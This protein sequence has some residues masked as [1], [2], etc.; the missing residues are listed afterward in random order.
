MGIG[1]RSHRALIALILAL[2]L[3]LGAGVG[4]AEAKKKGGGKSRTLS[5]TGGPG[6]VPNGPTSF[7]CVFI[8][9]QPNTNPV[10]L[11]AVATV[12]KKASGKVITDVDVTLS[13][14]GTPMSNNLGAVTDLIVRITGPDG[15]TSNLVLGARNCFFGCRAGSVSG[16][17]I[18]GLTL[19]DQTA[20]R[21][22]STFQPPPPPP[23]GDPDA[24]L[25]SPY[26]GTA[27][28]TTPL[29][30]LNGGPARGTYTLTAFDTCGATTCDNGVSTVSS[31][32]VEVKTVP[33]SN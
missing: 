14:L 8:F 4:P 6:A 32:R 11:R 30:K 20:T 9:C 19:S 25:T 15:A 12:G 23:C 31:W 28:P 5:A 33:A 16:N 17:L 24:T 27:R 1:R 2:C 26:T 22:C 13:V 18:S 3:T 29:K 7:S 21:T 10:P